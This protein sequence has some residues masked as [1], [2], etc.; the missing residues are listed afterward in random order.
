MQGAPARRLL[1]Y[2]E[3]SP[4]LEATM[5]PDAT[6]VKAFIWSVL[7]GLRLGDSGAVAHIDAH[8]PRNKLHQCI[9]ALVGGGAAVRSKRIG[10]DAAHG[11]EV[12]VGVRISNVESKEAQAPG[13]RGAARTHIEGRL[14]RSLRARERSQRIRRVFTGDRRCR[15]FQGQMPRRRVQHT[16][17]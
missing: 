13:L 2:K 9:H 6:R 7:R 16:G 8:E 1:P 11:C 17:R 4:I 15:G 14:G 10:A 3:S 5:A 12:N